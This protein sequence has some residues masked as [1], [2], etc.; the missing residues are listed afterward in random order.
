MPLY[1]HQLVI[2]GNWQHRGRLAGCDCALTKL[3]VY[4]RPGVRVE[5]LAWDAD[6][7]SEAAFIARHAPPDA[8]PLVCIY[9]YSWGFGW[10][11]IQLARELDRLHIPVYGMKV[12]DG[13]Y[14]HSY[15]CGNWR[16]LVPGSVVR[17]PPNVR[18][19]T[20]HLMQDGVELFVQRN[21]LLRGH[22]VV[23]ADGAEIRPVVIDYV[24][25]PCGHWTLR[26]PATHYNLDESRTWHK[27]CC[28]LAAE[29]DA[30]LD[31]TERPPSCDAV[32]L[33]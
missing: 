15:R 1:A 30:M 11:A 7:R 32:T 2:S 31:E 10:G 13:V 5:S 6:W 25:V 14:R 22:R 24:D 26:A 23:D 12:C 29:V 18:R 3:D 8:D 4:R 27:A 20:N 16:A 19:N 9:P 33:L 17:L 28:E 21:S